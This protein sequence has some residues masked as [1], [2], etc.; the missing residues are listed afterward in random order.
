[1]IDSLFFENDELFLVYNE[2]ISY[3]FVLTRYSNNSLLFNMYRNDML[4]NSFS[5]QLGDERFF[6]LENSSMA[7]FVVS[8]LDIGLENGRAARIRFE[9]LGAL[10]V[11][12]NRFIPQDDIV[13]INSSSIMQ[14]ITPSLGRQTILSVPGTRQLEVILTFRGY[15]YTR[16]RLD[17]NMGVINTEN[18]SGFFANGDR[19]QRTMRSDMR[20]W[21]S[22]AEQVVLRV[23]TNEVSLGRAGEV[24]VK[25]LRW[26]WNGATR[27]WDLVLDNV[28]S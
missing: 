15:S 13:Q 7:N 23:G 10:V 9:R 6:R 26:F 19:I 28:I 1:V 25:D 8:L 2:E 20:L 12:S 17:N 18:F 16:F 4:D 22:D 3:R 27:M 5:L 24:V 21:V 11:S 14:T